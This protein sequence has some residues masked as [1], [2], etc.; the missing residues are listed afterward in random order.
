MRNYP[1]IDLIYAIMTIDSYKHG[2]GS[3]ITNLGTGAFVRLGN[4][5]IVQDITQV[6]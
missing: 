6:N 5:S 2:Y 4:Y 3:D 1:K